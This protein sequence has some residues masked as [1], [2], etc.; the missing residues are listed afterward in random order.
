MADYL[1]SPTVESID[2]SKYKGAIN[3]V[4]SITAIDDFK[5]TKVE[6]VILSAAGQQLEAGTAIQDKFDGTKWRYTATVANA[7]LAGTQVTVTAYDTPGNEGSLT[8]A[9]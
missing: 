1:T 3:D 9:V 4:I 5:V 2:L 6:V 7:L 8:K